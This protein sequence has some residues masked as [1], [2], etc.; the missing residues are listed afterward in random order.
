M[1]GI[2]LLFAV[3]II[4][5]AFFFIPPH[6]TSAQLGSIGIGLTPFGGRII[7]ITQCST[8]PGAKLLLLSK[9]SP[10][11]YVYVPPTKYREIPPSK[12]DQLLLGVAGS[13]LT[14]WKGDKI[15]GYGKQITNRGFILFGSSF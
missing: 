9:P 12:I 11:Q 1:I 5:G 10:D 4:A 2:L 14:C 3:F 6:A 7:F 8:P 15:I 13:R